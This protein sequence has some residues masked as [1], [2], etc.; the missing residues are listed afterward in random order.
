[1]PFQ[2][3][4]ICVKI[5]TLIEDTDNGDAPALLSVR[6]SSAS[7]SPPVRGFRPLTGSFDLNRVR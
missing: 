7:A 1:M 5:S 4:L 6:F 3:F 2:V